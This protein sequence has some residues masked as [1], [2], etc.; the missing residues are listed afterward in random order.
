M[1]SGVGSGVGPGVGPGPPPQPYKTKVVNLLMLNH[2]KNT[3]KGFI[4]LLS[5]S[6]DDITSV[7]VGSFVLCAVQ[8]ASVVRDIVN[9]I[10][11]V[12]LQFTSSPANR[13]IWNFG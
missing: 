5:R 9:V 6:S 7:K 1:G 10:F 3:H 4:I 2:L 13:Y 11:A 8:V 12:W